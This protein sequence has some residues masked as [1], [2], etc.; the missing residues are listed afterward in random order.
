MAWGCF[1]WIP[2]PYKKWNEEDRTAMVAML[3]LVGTGLGLLTALVWWAVCVLT[4]LA[5]VLT[6]PAGGVLMGALDAAAAGATAMPA[7]MGSA[8]IL[9]GAVVTAAYFLMTGF[10]HLDG[11]MDVS[12][13]MMPRHPRL[14]ERRRILKDPHTGSFAAVSMA[15]MLLVFAASM[16]ALTA[17]AFGGAALTGALPV[18]GTPAGPMITIPHALGPGMLVVIAVV[19]TSRCVSAVSVICCR[20]METSQYASADF[21][22]P[23][24]FRK[25]LPA[26]VITVLMVAIC[27]ILCLLQSGSGMPGAPGLGAGGVGGMYAALA[28]LTAALVCALTAI[29]LGR[30]D[31]RALGGMNGDISGHIITSGEMAGVLTAAIL[32]G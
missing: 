29:I 21:G 27:V 17:D 12:D 19:T 24:A 25:A 14:E 28:V 15:L 5:D 2:C 11:F 1:C 8:P 22:R 18:A 10:I 32:L 13:A 4:R 23:G 6:G 9:C 7:S 16:A 31:R 3:P 30:I 26:L 20:S